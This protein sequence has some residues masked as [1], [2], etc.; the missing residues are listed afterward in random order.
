MGAFTAA[1]RRGRWSALICGRGGEEVF[2]SAPKET[3]NATGL[4][5]CAAIT[6]LEMCHSP[7]YG[8][9]A[10][11]HAARF[12]QV[13][14]TGLSKGDSIG[15]RHYAKL[16]PNLSNHADFGCADSSIDSGW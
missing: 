12:H 13:Q 3:R 6:A 15:N 8:R 9:L 1:M 7:Q 11:W 2:T 4:T 16:L 5:S 14:I 10:V